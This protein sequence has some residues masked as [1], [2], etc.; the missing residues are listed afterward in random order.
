MLRPRCATTSEEPVAH[1]RV[2]CGAAAGF[3]RGDGSPLLLSKTA[4]PSGLIGVEGNLQL[5]TGRL[6]ALWRVHPHAGTVQVPSIGPQ[7]E[8][9]SSN[10]LINGGL[11]GCKGKKEE[12]KGGMPAG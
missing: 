1:E 11:A 4:K 10:C 8:G 6:A 5:D 9:F 12:G 7:E 3:R 2:E